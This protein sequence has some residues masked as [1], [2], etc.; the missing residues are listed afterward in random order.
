[1]GNRSV[2]LLFL[3]IL[4]GLGFVVLRPAI[5]R[6]LYSATTPRP[7]EARGVLADAERSTIELFER[8]SPSVVQVVG[9]T[10]ANDLGQPGG[11]EENGGAQSGTGFVWDGAGNIVTN[12]HVVENTNA[13]AVR[14]AT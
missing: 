10:G 13:L 5:E 2:R 14:L 4:L 12:N 8:D 3:L 7:V 11:G 1:M 6:G 9:R